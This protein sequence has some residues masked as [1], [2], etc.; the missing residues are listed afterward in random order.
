VAIVHETDPRWSTR[1]F[2]EM[3]TIFR[4]RHK[5]GEVERAGLKGLGCVSLGEVSKEE[6]HKLSKKGK[7]RKREKEKKRKKD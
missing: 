7:K 2:K 3:L 6:L 5:V 4:R 1:A